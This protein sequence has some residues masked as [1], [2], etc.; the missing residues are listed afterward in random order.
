MLTTVDFQYTS[1]AAEILVIKLQWGKSHPK[2]FHVNSYSSPF[3]NGLQRNRH[4]KCI[5]K[6]SLNPRQS[7]PHFDNNMDLLTCTETRKY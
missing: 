6:N 1:D 7:S 2:Y 3:H 4:G 5:S